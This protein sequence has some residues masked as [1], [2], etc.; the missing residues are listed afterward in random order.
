MAKNRIINTEDIDPKLMTAARQQA[1]AKKARLAAEAE[2]G[3]SDDSTV[4]MKGPAKIEDERQCV[5]TLDLAPHSDRLVIDNVIY[6]HGQT[7]TVGQRLFDTMREMQSRGWQHQE[8][9]DGKDRNFYRKS[10]TVNLTPA[11]AAMPAPVLSRQ[12]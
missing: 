2:L 3:I 10:K 4:V 1:Q 9:I 12:A 6:M 7:Y 5:I 11:N 8:E